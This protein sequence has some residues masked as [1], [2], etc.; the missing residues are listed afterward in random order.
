[1]PRIG[2]I[3]AHA[4]AKI[5]ADEKSK[6]TIKRAREGRRAEVLIRVARK[7]YQDDS[8]LGVSFVSS[9]VAFWGIFSYHHP[10]ATTH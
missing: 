3:G 9:G 7:V 10:Q 2:Q 1:M 4:N 6:V 8:F 5:T